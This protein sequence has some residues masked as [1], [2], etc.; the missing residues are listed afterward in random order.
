VSGAPSIL[1]LLEHHRAVEMARRWGC[2]SRLSKN[3]GQLAHPLVHGAVTGAKR[4]RMTRRARGV[5]VKPVTVAVQA[6][7][8]VC[9]IRQDA[10]DDGATHRL[11]GCRS[12]QS[13]VGKR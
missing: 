10:T 8:H 6:A 3:E 2:A 9:Q 7:G 12:A 11:A 1:A 5:Y 4:S 13:E